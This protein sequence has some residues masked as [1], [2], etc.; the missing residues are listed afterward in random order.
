[1]AVYQLRQHPEDQTVN[2]SRNLKYFGVLT[3]LGVCIFMLY[4]LL[5]LLF[6]LCFRIVCFLILFFLLWNVF[7]SLMQTISYC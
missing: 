6:A 3:F 7:V 5:L 2:C 4:I 1:M